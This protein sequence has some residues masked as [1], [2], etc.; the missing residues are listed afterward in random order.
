[1]TKIHVK[2]GVVLEGFLPSNREISA[3]MKNVI[4]YNRNA[5]H[6]IETFPKCLMNNEVYLFV[7]G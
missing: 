7:S 5:T 6:D 2:K 4:I 3:T 1:M